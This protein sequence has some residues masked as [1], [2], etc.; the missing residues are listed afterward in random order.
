MSATTN[1]TAT[2]QEPE[3]VHDR[4]HKLALELTQPLPGSRRVYITGRSPDILV[5][6]REIG[7]ADTASLFGA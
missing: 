7:Q 6:M 5:P 3:V 4:A 2:R 1:G